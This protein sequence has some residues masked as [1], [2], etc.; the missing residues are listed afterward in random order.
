[1][2][3]ASFPGLDG[4][5]PRETLTVEHDGDEYVLDVPA[6]MSNY[7]CIYGQ[8]CRGT[9]PLEGEGRGRRR[10]EDASVTGCC[11]T[12]PVY[13]K[14]SAE[15]TAGDEASDDSPLRVAPFV[16]E[17]QPDEAQ[18]F[19]RI[20]AGDWHTEDQ[21]GDGHWTARHTTERGN[22]I[23][24]N[25]EMPNGKTGC[26]LFHVAARLG[27]DP[28]DTR[29][30][31]CHTAPAAAFLL[32]NALRGGGQRV[33]VTLQPHWF[34]WFAAE[35][36]FCTDDPAAFSA[37][38]PVFRRMAAEFSRLLGTEVYAALAPALEEIWTERAERM[39]RSWGRPVPIPA[40]IWAG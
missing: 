5:L 17:L 3:F 1:M 14:A 26:A 2:H 6:L 38:E 12:S 32:D 37:D 20:A 29:P 11:R 33:L 39:R 21:D 9:T 25:T 36:Y 35:G 27:V 34:G 31:S 7:R 10:P 19:D 4:P 24:L 8:G 15:V 40:P 30:F 16:A 18:H 13:R 28:K 22:C 23:F